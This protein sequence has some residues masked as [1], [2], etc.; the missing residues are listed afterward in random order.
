MICSVAE[1]IIYTPFLRE[2]R[3]DLLEPSIIFKALPERNFMTTPGIRKIPTNKPPSMT[4]CEEVKDIRVS[5]RP[6]RANSGVRYPPSSIFVSSGLHNTK[7]HTLT[8]LSSTCNLFIPASRCTLCVDPLQ[9]RPGVVG[10]EAVK[11]KRAA[12]FIVCIIPTTLY[13]DILAYT[14]TTVYNINICM[15]TEHD[16]T[17]SIFVITALTAFSFC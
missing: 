2:A 12:H 7:H 17:C 10:G 9:A 14:T 3:Q 15:C 13:F 8:I 6:R 11:G 4:L 1:R 16:T 5:T